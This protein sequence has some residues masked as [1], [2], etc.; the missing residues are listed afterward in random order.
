MAY[1]GFGLMICYLQCDF[2]YAVFKTAYKVDK[3]F[4]LAI[5][6]AAIGGYHGS[7]CSFSDSSG[8]DSVEPNILR[9]WPTLAA[10]V[11]VYIIDA[12]CIRGFCKAF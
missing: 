5:I 1:Y 12:N 3:A 11:V 4:F 8:F 10:G 2:A 9:Q 6:P 7:V